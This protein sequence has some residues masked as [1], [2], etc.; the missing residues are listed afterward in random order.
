MQ[1]KT[2]DGGFVVDVSGNGA[3]PPDVLLAS[4]GSCMGVYI[5]KYAK[6]TSL[7]IEGF[8]IE[9]TAEFQNVKPIRFSVIN[10]NISL[11]D[12]SITEKEKES[13]LRFVHNCPI[14]NTLKNPSDIHIKIQ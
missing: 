2:K 14:H 10:V 8:D 7:K 12:S 9:V 11:K 1:V 6:G 13:L 3:T 5:Q 4:L